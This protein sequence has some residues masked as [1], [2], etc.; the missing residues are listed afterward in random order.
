MHQTL[1]AYLFTGSIVIVVLFQLALMCGMPWGH[2]AM[3]GRYPGRFPPALRVAAF[4]QALVLSGFALVALTKAGVILPQYSDISDTA[5]WVVAGISGLS[6]IMNL[7]TP[8]KWE[9]ILWAPVAFMMF[10]T[11]GWLAMRGSA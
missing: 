5:I 10:L 9:R 8:S 7:A 3:G 6:L 4:V 11:S 2:L 1:A